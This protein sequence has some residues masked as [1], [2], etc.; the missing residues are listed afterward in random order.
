MTSASPSYLEHAYG[1]DLKTVGLFTVLAV[2]HSNV[3]A[4]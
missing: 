1:L 2:A 4:R 3:V